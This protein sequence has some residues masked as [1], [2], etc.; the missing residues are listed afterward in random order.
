VQLAEHRYLY[1]EERHG[2][3]GYALDT[4]SVDDL[5]ERVDSIG[6]RRLRAPTPTTAR[7][8]PQKSSAENQMT[9][10]LTKRCGQLS[11]RAAMEGC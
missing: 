5:D 4:V 8:G 3:S 1:I 2:H 9:E 7:P 11:G 10:P 6:D